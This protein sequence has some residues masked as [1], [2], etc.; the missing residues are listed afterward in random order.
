MKNIRII[1][2]G[3][4][5]SGIL[6]QL[7]QYPEDWGS[8]KNIENAEQQ[9]PSKYT[10]TTDVL[11]LVM[12]GITK[13]STRVLNETSSFSTHSGDTLKSLS[14][15]LKAIEAHRS[16]HKRIKETLNNPVSSRSNL[17]LV[18]KVT[19]NTGVIGYVTIV[20]TAGRE[21]PTELFKDYIEGTTTL[22]SF[23]INPHNKNLKKCGVAPVC[24]AD[25]L[26]AKVVSDIIKEGFYINESLNHLAYYFK[27][28]NKKTPIVSQNNLIPYNTSKFF[29]FTTK[30]INGK[31]TID[32]PNNED[33]LMIPILNFLDNL[34]KSKGD[35]TPSKP[36]KFITIVCVQSIPD[37]CDEIKKSLEFAQSISSSA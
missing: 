34:G 20:D 36:T 18:F 2:T 26:Q 29:Q 28:K 19:F 21:N 24:P 25:N 1:Q 5:V 8:Q 16:T 30:T 31:T 7:Y 32:K 17:Y 4:D 9:D 11:Q 23:I 12:G 35:N 15:L 14:D 3:V 37:K 10:T 22:Q 33:N 13:D 27:N 6:N